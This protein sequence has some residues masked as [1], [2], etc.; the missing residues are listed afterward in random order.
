MAD[1]IE[2]LR[3]KVSEYAEK[4]KSLKSAS[5]QD[6][7]AIGAAVKELLAAKQSFADANGGIG[8]DGKPMG[9]EKKKK[10]PPVQVSDWIRWIAKATDVYRYSYIPQQG[11]PN[12]ATAQK[13]AAKKAAKAAK[14]QA[15]QEGKA[16]PAP[17]DE[18]KSAPA[19]AKATKAPIKGD[20]AA[21]APL[22][23]T[24]NPNLPL[25]ERPVVALSV[26]VLTN[27]CHEVTVQSNHLGENRLGTPEGLTLVG[28]IAMARYL[29]RRKGSL[30]PTDSAQ[31]ALQ[32]AWIDYSLSISKLDA[33]QRAKAISLTL[34]NHNQTYLVGHDMSLADVALFACLG[35][36]TQ[37]TD[38]NAVLASCPK[39]ATAV[40][41]WLNLMAAHPGLQ[42][43]TQIAVGITSV[44]AQIDPN[45]ELDPLVEG[46]NALEGALP[47]RVV[48]R[49]PPGKSYNPNCP[50]CIRL[51]C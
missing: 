14:K 44:Q 8:V 43:A 41:R 5:P 24:I 4:V 17:A 23:L 40:R 13:K 27:T 34:E 49:F 39:E 31:Q 37:P 10:E 30:I 48:T 6:K 12:S 46:M 25:T 19:P 21:V 20:Q 33:A 2:G 36:P 51:P 45:V 50:G 22:T 9:G 28:D 38:L 15:Y 1:N 18:V 35:F 47:G 16:K 26:M 42:E 32:D 11:D 7:E 3:A 29:A